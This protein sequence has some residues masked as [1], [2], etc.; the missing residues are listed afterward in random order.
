[1]FTETQTA[2]AIETLTNARNAW[3]KA[4]AQL[5]ET[6]WTTIGTEE[7]YPMVAIAEPVKYGYSTPQGVI[8]AL[9]PVNGKLT[10]TECIGG[11]TRMWKKGELVTP[12]SANELA[13]WDESQIHAYLTRNDFAGRTVED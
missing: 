6:S 8:L 5:P 2:K 10:W 12:I 3:E 9:I 7:T 4:A 13:T 1:M 11:S